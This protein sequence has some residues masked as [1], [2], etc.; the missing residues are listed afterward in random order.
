[1][2]RFFGSSSNRDPFVNMHSEFQR[3]FEE[4]DEMMSRFHYGNF[5]MIDN[6]P[7]EQ[8]PPSSG[9]TPN[10]ESLRDNFLKSSATKKPNEIVPS[11]RQPS[12]VSKI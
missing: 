12:F 3:M 2:R 7:F 8:P 6:V 1:M 10:S 4:M 11:Y 9:D 5:S